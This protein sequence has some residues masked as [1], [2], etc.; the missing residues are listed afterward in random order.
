[1]LLREELFSLVDKLILK[2]IINDPIVNCYFSV[3][4]E[5]SDILFLGGIPTQFDEIL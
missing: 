3:V 4:I 1:M 2:G 5:P